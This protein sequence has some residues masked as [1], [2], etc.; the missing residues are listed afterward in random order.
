MIS[1]GFTL[2]YTD[3]ELDEIGQEA[4]PSVQDL[5]EKFKEEILPKNV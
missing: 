5:V 1:E 2:G 3:A 4:E